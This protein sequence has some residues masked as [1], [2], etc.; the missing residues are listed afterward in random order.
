MDIKAQIEEI[1]GKIKNDK[2]LAEAFKQNPVQA[3]EKLLGIDLPDETITKIVD[4]VKAALAGND[5]AGILG[6]LKNLFKK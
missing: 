2:S 3:V 1:V 4:G 5:A 6:K